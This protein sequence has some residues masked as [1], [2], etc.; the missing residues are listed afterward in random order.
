MIS[1]A[2]MSAEAARI[3]PTSASLATR[4]VSRRSARRRW[5]R[6]ALTRPLARSLARRRVEEHLQSI[7]ILYNYYATKS[8]RH[9]G[10]TETYYI[11]LTSCDRRREE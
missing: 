7:Q 11:H 4:L 3:R 2:A 6:R 5:K 10:G 8:P 1:L 9:E